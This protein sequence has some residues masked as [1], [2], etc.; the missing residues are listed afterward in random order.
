MKQIH[1][2][3]QKTDWDK[4]IIADLAFIKKHLRYPI[5][6][7]T[8]I[9]LL[10]SG[11][12]LILLAR[13]LFIANFFSK[14]NQ[15]LVF[16]AMIIFVILPTFVILKRYIDLI[17]FFPVRTSFSI[18]V[19]MQ[20]LE[21]FLKEQ[22][23]VTFRHS[24]APEIYQIISKNISAVGDEREV[25]IF[26]V[27]DNRI[28]INSHFTSSRKWFRLFSAPTRHRQMIKQLEIWLRATTSIHL[29]KKI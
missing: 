25:L 23:L 17:R 16:L 20:L 13:P 29:Q 9:P 26:I 2:S 3:S 6:R 21:R 19:N 15:L 4:Q 10:S 1:N 14:S 5:R 28:L 11:L 12:V 7:M 24:E 22:R 8:I 27:D 18:A